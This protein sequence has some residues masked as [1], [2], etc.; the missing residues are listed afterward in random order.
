MNLFL[1]NMIVK[2]NTSYYD[3][4]L[5]IIMAMKTGK[6]TVMTDSTYYHALKFVL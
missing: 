5:G 6:N 4:D 2:S 1:N 3:C